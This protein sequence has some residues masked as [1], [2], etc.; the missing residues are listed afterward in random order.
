METKHQMNTGDKNMV[1]LTIDGKQIEVPEGST[2]LRAAQQEGIHI[3]TLCDHPQLTPFGGCRLCLVEVKGA[4][5]L[6][7]SC[8]IPATEGM[9]VTTDNESIKKARKF[10][11]SMIFSER[12]HFCPF[13]Q[14]SGGDCE[15]QNSAYEQ[16]MTHWMIQPNWNNYRVD[17]S[18]PYFTHEANRCILCRR[19]IRTCE[20]LVGNFTLGVEERG[21]LTMVIADQGIPL[22]ESSCIS[23]G[24]CVQNCPT[25]AMMDNR[26]AYHGLKSETDTINT[27]CTGCSLGCGLEILVHDNQIVA[28]N[29]DYEAAINEG[30]I[31]KLG[32][33]Q[34]LEKIETSISL[35]TPLVR[36]SG[37]LVETTWEEAL[38]FAAEAIKNTKDNLAAVA[39]TELTTETLY[40]FKC[41]FSNHLNSNIVTS[42]ETDTYSA[43]SN[44]LLKNGALNFEGNIKSVD[45]ADCVITIGEDL[46]NQHEV[47]GFM[48]KR[49]LPKGTTFINI[50]SNTEV[51][52][53]LANCTMQIAEG[54]EKEAVRGIVASM[55]KLGLINN[56]CEGIKDTDALVQMAA[57]ATGVASETFLDAAYAIANAKNP[58]ILYGPGITREDSA[59]TLTTISCLA[60][61]INGQMISVKGKANSLSAIQLGLD[62]PLTDST[63]IKTAVFALADDSD[64]DGLL[65]KLMSADTK[66]I[67]SSVENAL[68]KA[69]D[70]V[71]PICNWAQEEGHFINMSGSIQWRRK[72]MDH[73]ENIKPAN[74]AILALAEVLGFTI[75]SDWKNAL[76]TRPSSVELA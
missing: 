66:I 74:D 65:N 19:C 34:Q 61:L 50:D 73:S 39:S 5:T 16:D 37:E 44:V 38:E 23:C 10:V 75:D 71:F 25:G 8:T 58:V 55:T 41:L 27:I 62:Q 45:S 18:H 2:V 31:C 52:D 32:R 30:I 21:A 69:A 46:I 6:Q 11:L 24:M 22:G 33:W 4:R 7:P 36:K 15:L 17:S 63:S 70:V 53:S 42:T 9:E 60:G 35:T 57:K 54:S 43:A 51:Y 48:I 12:N 14:V 67:F 76:L 26:S 72:V 13:C 29:G 40:S 59:D 1:H 68:T 20:E 28:I 64:S 3:P 56:S 49:N 47:V